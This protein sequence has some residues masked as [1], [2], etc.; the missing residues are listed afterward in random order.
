MR[1][2]I[3]GMLDPLSRVLFGLTTKVHATGLVRVDMER[4][5]FRHGT[6]WLVQRQTRHG[7][8]KQEGIPGAEAAAGGNL[9]LLKWMHTAGYAIYSLTADYAAMGGKLK[10][11][12]WLQDVEKLHWSKQTLQ[13]GI[14]SGNLDMLEWMVRNDCPDPHIQTYQAVMYGHLHVLQWLIKRGHELYDRDFLIEV[15]KKEGFADIVAWLKQQ[16]DT[17]RRSWDFF[18]NDIAHHVALPDGDDDDI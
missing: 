7:Q 14:V 3:I 9:P 17:A 11:L 1:Q 10:V 2:V 16:P 4:E 12:Q 13:Q 6:V 18:E 8:K 5:L 15:A